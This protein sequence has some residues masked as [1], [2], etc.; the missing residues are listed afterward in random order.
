[1]NTA[2]ETTIPQPMR[3]EYRRLALLASQGDDEAEKK[4]LAIEKRIEDHERQQRRH[5]AAEAEAARVTVEAQEKAA[6]AER[7]T[8]EA[9]HRDLVKQR[10][11]G[12]RAIEIASEALASAVHSTLEIDAEVWSLA[13]Q[14]GW[15]PETRT[16][17]TITN[18]IATKLGRLGAGLS[19]MPTPTHPALRGDL[20]SKE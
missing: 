17:A 3:D 6:A 19:D 5:E 1:M 7:E 12:Y 11:E 8:K 18:Y 10:V 9:K 14:L 20:V 4:L 13:L 16:S 15:S 2:P